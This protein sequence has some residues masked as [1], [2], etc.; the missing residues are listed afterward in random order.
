MIE[1]LVLEDDLKNRIQMQETVDIIILSL[2]TY[3]Y[4]LWSTK[5]VILGESQ[6]F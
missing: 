2:N 5:I 1:Q 4:S 6:I 3:R